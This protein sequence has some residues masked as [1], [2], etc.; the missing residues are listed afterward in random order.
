MPGTVTTDLADRL[1]AEYERLHT[2][3]EDAFWTVYMGLAS[4]R[5]AARADFDDK[6]IAL[7]QWLQDP[8]RLAEVDAALRARGA[9]GLPEPSRTALLGWQRTL[10]AHAIADVGARRLGE[11]LVREEGALARARA[12]MALGYR[13]TD[14]ALVPASS[15]RLGAMLL[16]EPDAALRKGAWEGLRSIETCALENGFLEIVKR[17]NRF[18]RAL[19]GEDFYDATVRRTEGLT[20]ARIFEWLDELEAATRDA[21]RVAVER[22]AA[23]HGEPATPWNIRY[24]TAGDITREQDAYFPFRVALAR[25]G[26]SFA[27]LGVDYRGAELVLD[28]VDRKGKHENGFMHG[29]VPAWRKDGSFRPARIQFTANAIPGMVGAGRR[30]FETLFHEGGHAAH[31]A[32]IDMPSPCFSQEFAPTSVAF[33]ETQSMFM[34]SLLG[35]ADWQARYATDDEGRAM[36]PELIERGLRARQP[37]AAWEL[38]QRLS[39][40]Y[41][42]KALYEIPDDELTPER[43]LEELRAVERRLLFLEEGSPRPILSV[44][45][46]LAGE[47]SA[48][49][50]GY[51]LAEMAVYQT[52]AFLLARDGHL[53]DNARIGPTLREAYWAPGNSRGFGDFVRDLTG[54]PLSAEHLAR[55]VNRSPD[56]AA[57]E[58]RVALGKLADVPMPSGP[59]ELEATIRVMH[60]NQRVAGTED[61]GFEKCADAFAAWI[62]AQAD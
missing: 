55:H 1:D 25:W 12:A 17:R 14:G 45:H 27:A 34:D 16:S 18:G 57:A 33:A 7:K 23:E 15:V 36:S 29:P 30:A 43:V 61:G 49:Y 6:E 2:A 44:P 24:W 38:R 54:T 11:E 48:Y 42:E 10:S 53:V 41:G 3:K 46:L 35:D 40:C 59:V 28:L 37:L 26:R 20:K 47:A 22:L 39:V 62:D 52:R 58:G 56:E 19:G 13:G 32:N 9:E 4:D 51:V 60:G 21:G 8:E 5:D 31:F 50:H